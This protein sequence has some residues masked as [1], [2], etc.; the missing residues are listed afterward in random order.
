MKINIVMGFFLPMPPDAGGAVEKSWHRLSQEFV[1]SGH[2]VTIISRTWSGWPNSEKREGVFHRRYAG[3]NHTSKL[4]KNLLRDFLWSLRITRYIPEADIT[5]VNCIFLPVWLKFIRR[6]VGKLIVMPGRMPKKQFLFYYNLD[7]ILAVS[8]PVAKAISEERSNLSSITNVVGYPIDWTALACPRG[9]KDIHPALTIGFVGRLHKEKGLDLFVASLQLL[10]KNKA[11]P[12]WKVLICGPRD[13]SQGGS[14]ATYAA[15]IERRLKEFLDPAQLDIRH[16]IYS[17][18]KLTS[19]YQE[20]DIFCYPSLATKG[21]TFGVSVAE[22]MA[23]GAVPIV[24]SLPCFRDFVSSGVT[25][26]MF[27]HKAPDAAERLS[28]C[29]EMLIQNTKLRQRMSEEARSSVYRYDYSLYASR[30]LADFA[31]LSLNQSRNG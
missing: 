18:S 21:E 4:W 22:A 2:E 29:L 31:T 7:Y 11:L 3:F 16:P 28:K 6:K 10:S 19:L 9:Q 24:S 5:I 8:T 13:V 20:I 25:G 27:D 12:P 23:A 15:E 30:L 14:G 1:K 26:E 17:F